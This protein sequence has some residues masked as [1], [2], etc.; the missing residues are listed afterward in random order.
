M[1]RSPAAVTYWRLVSSMC[2]LPDARFTSPV[3]HDRHWMSRILT[4]T[5]FGT[6]TF[7]A[8]GQGRL[9]QAPE[10]QVRPRTS[11]AIAA[12][13]SPQSAAAG[14]TGICRYSSNSSLA[15][16]HAAFC[17]CTSATAAHYLGPLGVV[18][19]F[20]GPRSGMLGGVHLNRFGQT[21]KGP[22]PAHRRRAAPTRPAPS[23]PP[24]P[25]PRCHP[26]SLLL[27]CAWQR[28]SRR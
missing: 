7:V 22:A 4:N 26:V 8:A 15:R 28:G 12:R 23:R 27:A 1:R 14:S 3:C 6:V 13:Y 5:F 19:H 18:R 20:L 9:C 16:V 10:P 17:R 21:V 11:S 2:M 25:A 24:S